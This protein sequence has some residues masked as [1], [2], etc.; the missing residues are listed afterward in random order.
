VAPGPASGDFAGHPVRTVPGVPVRQFQMGL[1]TPGL[2]RAVREFR[3]DVLHAASPFVVGARAISAAHARGLPCLAVYQTH[4]PS[5]VRQHAPRVVGTGAA[6]ATWRWIRR[7]HEHADLTLAPSTPTLAELRAHGIPR[8]AL[9]ARGVDTRQFHPGRRDEAAT[10]SLRKA[11]APDGEVVVGYVGRLAPEKELHRLSE[12]V[13]LDGTRLVVVG[14]GP[15]RADVEA[16]LARTAAHSRS[17]VR[18]PV[19][20]GRLAGDDLARAYAALDVFVHTGTREAFGQT[21]QEAAATGVPVVAPARGGPLDLVRD[22]VTGHLYAPDVPGDLARRVEV[23]V[24]DASRRSAL[25]RAGRAR[26]RYRSWSSATERLID[27][28]LAATRRLRTPRRTAA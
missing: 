18:P 28:Y 2:A 21:L 27:H 26:V 12:V 7:V 6:R 24:R 10:R 13:P 5:Y 3:P 22:G 16:L 11:L 20:L 8:T 9:W 15:S 17:G 1:P 25:G 23:L 4:M 14:D 19:F